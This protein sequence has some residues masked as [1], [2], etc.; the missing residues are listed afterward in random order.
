MSIVR[1]LARPAIIV[2]LVAGGLAGCTQATANEAT[3]TVLGSW[4]AA[5]QKGFQA[6]VRAFEK[7]HDNRIH[8]VYIP[9]R[10][11][12]A[13]LATDIQNDDPPDLAV[14]PTPGVV[15]QYAAEGNLKPI[16]GALNLQAMKSQYSP[17]WLQLMQANGPSGKAYYAVIV[18]ATLKSVIWYDPNQFPARYRN[19]LT[20]GNLTWNQLMSLTTDL[21]ATGTTPWCIGM[22]DASSSGWPGTDWIE[23]IVLH[24]SLLD[25]SGLYWYNLWVKGKLAWTSDPIKQAFETFGQVA[26]STATPRL[27]QGGPAHELSTSY[28]SVGQ[29]LFTS[30]PGCYLD[31]E[32][33]FIT[34]INFYGQDGLGSA[35]S[36]RPPQSGTDFNF[37]PFPPLISADRNNIEV[38][39]DLLGMFNPTPATRAFIDYVTTPQAQEAWIGV[40]GSGGIS[41]NEAVPLDSYPKRDPVSR[42]IAEILTQPANVVFDA[43]DSMPATMATAFNNAVL[44]YIDD[45]EQLVAILNGLDQVRKAAYVGPGFSNL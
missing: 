34:G 20:S 2:L 36:G 6:M 19:L 26:A 44:Q 39:G 22:A 25:H 4:T 40:P 11:A 41:V 24:H 5:E 23:D 7:R 27:V 1:V 21:S 9:S 12:L 18:K 33:S 28:G 8:V 10:D 29:G 31:H 35:T 38:G 42:R 43:S 13:D 16:N 37:V 45:P 3:V 30:R 14:L 32:G 15:H 17:S